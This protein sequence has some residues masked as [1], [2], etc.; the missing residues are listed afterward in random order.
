MRQTIGRVASH[1]ASDHRFAR[2][3]AYRQLG[4]VNTSRWVNGGLQVAKHAEGVG[5]NLDAA[6]VHRIFYENI[7]ENT[8]S[9]IRR[10]LTHCG[11]PFEDSCLEFYKNKRAV[12]TASSEQVRQPIFQDG[13]HH[14]RNY[15]RWL[16]PAKAILGSIIES[17]AF[18]VRASC[19]EQEVRQSRRNARLALSRSSSTMRPVTP[20][21]E[22]KM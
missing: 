1:S 15:E 18:L 19:G 8:E 16:A 9:E 5:P 3:S 2:G 12:R 13:L 4:R 7:V 11:L 20:D 17:Y 21:V 22:S 6:R 10:L 14:W